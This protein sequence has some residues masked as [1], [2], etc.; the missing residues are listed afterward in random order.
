VSTDEELAALER[1]GWDA[2]TL[3]GEHARAFYAEALDD[4]AL[5]LLPGG[6]L[7][8]DRQTLLDAMAGPPWSSY[9]LEDLR[10]VR[11]TADTAVVAYGAVAQRA[12]E[13]EYSALMSSG[14]V[15]RAG[16]WRLALHQQ[17]PR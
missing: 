10:V 8:E 9:R 7:I 14:Y 6:L 15:K 11:P 3:G 1:A 4:A 13:A 2:L 16:G 17:T 5:M 12:G